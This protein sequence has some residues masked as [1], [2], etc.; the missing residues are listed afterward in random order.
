MLSTDGRLEPPS[1]GGPSIFS[2]IDTAIVVLCV[3]PIGNQSLVAK[4]TPRETTQPCRPCRPVPIDPVHESGPAM[5][6]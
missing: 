1:S 3:R 4:L 6:S 2:G 5:L